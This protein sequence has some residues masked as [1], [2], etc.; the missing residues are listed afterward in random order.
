MY[1]CSAVLCAIL[2]LVSASPLQA[3][4]NAKQMPSRKHS[5]HFLIE[6][7]FYDAVDSDRQIKT[8][9]L[10]TGAGYYPLRN[11]GLYGM[12]V[13]S[14]NDGYSIDE[15]NPSLGQ[16][17]ADSLGLGVAG[18]VRWHFVDI[19]R[20]SFFLDGSFGS[21]YYDHEFPPQGTRWNFMSRFGAG[22]SYRLNAK[23]TLGAGYRLM[24]ISN[25]NGLEEDNPA[26]D[27]R[28]GF[29]GLSWALE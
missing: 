28:A 24:H 11:L 21:M 18:M 29:I 26:M 17:D 2:F 20:F 10:D 16:M 19:A 25:G 3:A 23:F 15:F 1:R 4:P 14:K 5:W 22:M 13:L 6:S 9:N 7:E 27:S 8:Y 12:L